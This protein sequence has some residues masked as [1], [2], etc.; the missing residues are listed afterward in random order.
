MLQST[1]QLRGKTPSDP[2]MEEMGMGV[3]G[4]GVQVGGGC[5][6][7]GSGTYPGHQLETALAE[8]RERMSVKEEKNKVSIL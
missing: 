8:R 7:V 1:Y 6:G 4:G 2:R 5:A 3:W